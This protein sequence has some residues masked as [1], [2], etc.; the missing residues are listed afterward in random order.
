M[1]S[2]LGDRAPPVPTRPPARPPARPA[3]RFA[4]RQSPPPAP[5]LPPLPLSPHSAVCAAQRGARG[6]RGGGSE[7]TGQGRGGPEGM[8]G[9]L[10]RAAGQ[11]PTPRLASTSLPENASGGGRH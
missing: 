1:R 8:G 7:D 5:P 2:S 9:V 11:A 3:G 10:R 4:P 6:G